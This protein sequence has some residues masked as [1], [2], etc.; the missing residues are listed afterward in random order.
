MPVTLWGEHVQPPL[1]HYIRCPLEGSPVYRIVLRPPEG[2]RAQ[3]LQATI[4]VKASRGHQHAYLLQRALFLTFYRVVFSLAS[5]VFRIALD[6]TE[7]NRNHPLQA[8]IGV[9]ASRGYKQIH[10]LQRAQFSPSR[11]LYSYWPPQRIA[12]IYVL[13]RAIRVTLYRYNDLQR[14][15]KLYTYRG[16]HFEALEG[17]R[18]PE[19]AFVCGGYL[20]G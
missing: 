4:G 18:P 8:I 17:G 3:A 19:G 2:D 13:Q 14:I 6:P 15:Q 12:L 20:G 9:K 5:S 1:E 11:G 16:L 7:G 10:P